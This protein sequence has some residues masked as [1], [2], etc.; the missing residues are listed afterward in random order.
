MRY[1]AILLLTPW[2]MILAWAYWSYPK[3]LPRRTARRLFDVAV[4]LLAVVASVVSVSL[5]FDHVR[6]PQ[7]GQFGVPSG[8]IWQQ[9]LGVLI[10]Y[11]VFVAVL[12]LGLWLR[13]L[14]WGRR[15]G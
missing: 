4:V 6:L 9:V 15:R 12:L 1:L 14:A 5:G 10:A 7:A 11:G 8:S 2:L 13:Q 3:S